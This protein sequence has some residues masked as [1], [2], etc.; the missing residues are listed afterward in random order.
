MRVLRLDHLVLTVASIPATSAFY[1]GLGFQPVTFGDGRTALAFGDQKINLHELE[2]PYHPKAARPTLGAADL[3]FIVR[4][5]EETAEKIAASGIA[6]E[7]GPVARTGAI[8]PIT[9]IYVRDPDGNLIEFSE[10]QA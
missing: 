4:S 7:E 6:V 8:G 2:G 3:C 1:A 9:S 10:Y 5:L